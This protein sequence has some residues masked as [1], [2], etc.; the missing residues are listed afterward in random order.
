MPSANEQ[1]FDAQVRHQIH[2]E[3]YKV[4][5]VKRISDLL[6]KA[7]N[8]LVKK[9]GAHKG[10]PQ[11]WSQQRRREVLKS[12]R[13]AN[14]A[15]YQRM[16]KT[17]TNELLDLAPA[18]AE[19]AAD[20]FH[21][22]VPIDLDLT[23]PSRH[24][25][26]AAVTS[27][28]ILG[29][30]L[31]SWVEELG[32]SKA[33]RIRD[34]IN[35]GLVE[36]E[37]VDQMVARIRGTKANN[38]RD[39]VIE[40]SRRDAAAVVRTAVNHTTTQAREL[41]YAENTDL[42]KSVQWISTLDSRTTPI[43]RA[44]DGDLYAPNEGPRPPAHVGCR[45]TTVPITKSWEELG[46][47]LEEAP[48]GTRASMNGQVPAD[49]SYEQWLKRQ[50][51]DVVD[52][53][54]GKTKSALFIDGK[55]PLEKFVDTTG[56][57]LTLDQLKATSKG[58]WERAA[59]AN[60]G[61]PPIIQ[62]KMRDRLFYEPPQMTNA[63]NAGWRPTEAEAAVMNEIITSTRDRNVEFA[64]GFD[65]VS[66]EITDQVWTSDRMSS[67]N[68]TADQ[69]AEWRRLG[70][71][72]RQ[73]HM[74]HTHPL[75]ATQ[76]ENGRP[77]STSLSK[78]DLNV[79]FH[80]EAIQRVTAATADGSLFSA[81]K[82]GTTAAWERALAATRLGDEQYGPGTIPKNADPTYGFI[83]QHSWMIALHRA[84]LLRYSHALSPIQYEAV[85]KHRHQ[86]DRWISYWKLTLDQGRPPGAAYWTT[87]DVAAPYV[88]RTPL[89][90]GVFGVMNTAAEN[91]KPY[92]AIGRRQG[93]YG[94]IPE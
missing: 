66:G 2:L 24:L 16:G 40:M 28:P 49:L 46:L 26:E 65:I 42:I 87:R 90:K 1:I 18:E 73:L 7:D 4:G 91:V 81:E 67:V 80:Y 85:D 69:I 56:K 77:M 82:L 63:D 52:D 76:T 37:T 62:T 50:P 3:R 25:L 12:V 54:M 34:A 44:R 9:L 53:I 8:D 92:I 64:V 31:D 84:G 60:A 55:L 19:F 61:G 30:P 15:A 13:S 10:D 71:A 38:Y 33:R 20:L 29:K 39:G 22:F 47:D 58:A 27:K 89:V 59:D 36:G 74:I 93:Y 75:N 88:A 6:N 79:L 32:E 70:K 35:I 48:V 23:M 57:E 43:C 14:A 83:R 51:R 68:L 11:S 45:S 17:L 21:R 41:L 72:G 78:A 5:L 94:D 86:L